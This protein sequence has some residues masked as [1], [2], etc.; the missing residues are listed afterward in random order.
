MPRGDPPCSLAGTTPPL[1]CRPQH[2]IGI[3]V[4]VAEK[5]LG[6]RPSLLAPQL[7]GTADPSPERPEGR[8]HRER[9]PCSLYDRRVEAGHAPHAHGA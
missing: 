4:E 1:G 8:T 2:Q 5:S 6:A 9:H 7:R 3:E